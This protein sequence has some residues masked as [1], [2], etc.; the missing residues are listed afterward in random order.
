MQKFTALLVLF[1]TIAVV[2]CIVCPKEDPCK[3]VKCEDHGLC[4]EKNQ[5]VRK[6]GYCDCCN[7]CFT[8]LKENESC[9]A[10]ILRNVPQTKVCADGLV[11]HERKCIKKENYIKLLKDKHLN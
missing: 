5:E 7:V 3:F 9:F 4:S 1:L 10:S 8:V 11:C 2:N 6:G